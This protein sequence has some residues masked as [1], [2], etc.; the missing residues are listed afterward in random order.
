MNWR[1][2][3]LASKSRLPDSSPQISNDLTGPLPGPRASR[4]TR[5]TLSLSLTIHTATVTH[6]H[7]VLIERCVYLNAADRI[8]PCQHRNGAALADG[9]PTTPVCW[10]AMLHSDQTRV[11]PRH[12]P[13]WRP[14]HA[15]CTSGSDCARRSAACSSPGC[16]AT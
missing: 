8:G 9:Q 10:V 13:R 16:T 12:A 6:D 11:G 15:C 7:I 1:E 5:R 3:V 2:P 14:N 4:G